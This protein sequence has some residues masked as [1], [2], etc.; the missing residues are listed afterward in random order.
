MERI[1]KRAREEEKNISFE[2]LKCL[3]EKHDDWLLNLD[4]G[5][6]INYDKDFETKNNESFTKYFTYLN[7]G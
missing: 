7:D 2:Y 1:K 6:I 4:N 3:A 5:I